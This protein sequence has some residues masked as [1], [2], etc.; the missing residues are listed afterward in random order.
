MPALML[1]EQLST[2]RLLGAILVAVIVVWLLLSWGANLDPK[3]REAMLGWAEI[4][5]FAVMV[6]LAGLYLLGSG[7]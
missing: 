6:L 7:R 1:A 2:L 3:R 5:G 4:G